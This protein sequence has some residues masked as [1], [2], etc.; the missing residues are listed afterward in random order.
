MEIIPQIGGDLGQVMDML[1]R[2]LMAQKY[3]PVIIIGSDIP[4]LQPGTLRRALTA[5]NRADVCFG[6]S[7]DGGYYLVGAKHAISA[8]FQNVPW[9]TPGV[10]KATQESARRA[11][12]STASLEEF[13]DVDTIEDLSLLGEEICKLR[14]ESDAKIPL[15]TA[16]WLKAAGLNTKCND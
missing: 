14:S 15:R 6:P 3:T 11:G 10:L 2:R 5:L 1:M 4:A 7:S 16:A 8:L 12:L 9:S 13:S